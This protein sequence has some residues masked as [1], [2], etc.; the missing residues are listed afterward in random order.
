MFRMGEAGGRHK[1]CYSNRVSKVAAECPKLSYRESGGQVWPYWRGRRQEL[2]TVLSHTF[3]P[4]WRLS[5]RT[6]L[7]SPPHLTQVPALPAPP[8]CTFIG[9]TCEEHLV[10]EEALN[11]PQQ[12]VLHVLA[13]SLLTLLL[14]RDGEDKTPLGTHT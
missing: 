4:G 14:P 6:L 9:P 13:T 1:R 12:S 11:N 5:S 10:L 7:L 2:R 3:L 8:Q